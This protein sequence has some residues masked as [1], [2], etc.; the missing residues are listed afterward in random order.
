M[1]EKYYVVL[2]ET[3]PGTEFD[4]YEDAREYCVAAQRDGYPDARILSPNFTSRS[5][6]FEYKYGI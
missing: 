3:H 2:D 6:Y 5:D 4:T 1:T